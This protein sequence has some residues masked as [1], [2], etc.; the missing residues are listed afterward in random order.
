M[1]ILA[2]VVYTLTLE[3][4]MPFWDCGEFLASSYKLEVGHP[5]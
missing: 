3:P 4:T 2:T 1:F 5:P